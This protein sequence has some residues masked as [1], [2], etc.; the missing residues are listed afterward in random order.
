LSTAKLYIIIG[1]LILAVFVLIIFLIFGGFSP[2]PKRVQL[3]FWGTYDDPYIFSDIIRDF[4][5]IYPNISIRYR[6][7][8]FESYEKTVIDALAA[9][10][11]PD[12]W[13]IH[14]T[15]LPKHKDKL[16]PL[17]K[18][19]DYSLAD[20]K[21]DFVDVAEKDLVDDG[22]IYAV[23]LYIDTLALYYNKD[24]FNSAGIRTF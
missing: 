14:S 19:L 21:N 23:P 10:Q 3:E 20:F 4:K 15:W 9:G 18:D 22:K 17:P 8:P 6:S 2:G 5:K 11:G 24:L 13:M 16:R 1:V 7:I 12:I